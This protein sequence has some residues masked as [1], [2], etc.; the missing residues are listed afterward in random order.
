MGDGGDAHPSTLTS[1]LLFPMLSFFH[2]NPP[3]T[4]TVFSH[5]LTLLFRLVS[6]LCVI[7]FVHT[8]SLAMKG[9]LMSSLIVFPP[10][11]FV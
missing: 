9:H 1:S 2:E 4:V 11:R 7:C 8:L 5:L 6:P 10:R 3:C